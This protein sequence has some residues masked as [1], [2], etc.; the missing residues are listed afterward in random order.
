MLSGKKLIGCKWVFKIK[1]IID[2]TKKGI[3]LG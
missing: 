3:R 1:Y 2:G